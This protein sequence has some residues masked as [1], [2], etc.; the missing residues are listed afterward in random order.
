MC[1]LQPPTDD[2]AN[3]SADSP[4]ERGERVL[5]Q[6]ILAACA[7]SPRTLERQQ[8]MNLIV[9]MMQQSGKIWR[10]GYRNINFCDY[11]EALQRTWLYFSRN[12]CEAITAQEAY[13]PLKGSATNWF[14]SYLK[15]RLQDIDRENSRNRAIYLPSYLQFDG[16]GEIIEID[17]IE[18]LPAPAIVPSWL[19]S[20]VDWLEREKGRLQRIHLRDR[21]DINC[22]AIVPLRLPDREME[23]KVLSERYN[24]PISTICKFYLDR[25]LPQLRKFFLDEGW[26]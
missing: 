22:Y 19:E 12:L 8:K 18:N 14:N 24:V 10:G 9:R 26:S 11:E 2:N 20:I 16:N 17:P 5:T 15:R 7:S 21:P 6:L 13:N 25:C 3:Y 1:K 4:E 23:W